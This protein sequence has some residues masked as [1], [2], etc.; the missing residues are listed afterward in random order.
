MALY[1]E[2]QFYLHSDDSLK[3][4]QRQI[5][6]IQISHLNELALETL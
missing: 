3:I 1:Y 5:C 6:Q 2:E 4:M